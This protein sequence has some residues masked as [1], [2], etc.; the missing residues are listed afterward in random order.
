[1]NAHETFVTEKA[2]EFDK[3]ISKHGTRNIGNAL[4]HTERFREV[5]AFAFEDRYGRAGANM[6]MGLVQ[7]G[8]NTY[9]RI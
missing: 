3:M 8:E 6:L 2:K 9:M 4:A 5:L 1:M 7:A